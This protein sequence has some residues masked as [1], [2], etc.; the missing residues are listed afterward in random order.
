MKGIKMT[1]SILQSFLDYRFIKTDESENIT[2]L[3]KAVAEF[4]KRLSKK[5]EKII[6]YTLVALD[7]TISDDDPIVQ[8][9]EALIIKKWP[10][11]RN[12]VAK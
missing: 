2:N 6:P 1:D 11:F 3:N 12:S 7:P 9:V 5:K 4:Q 10:T 8:E